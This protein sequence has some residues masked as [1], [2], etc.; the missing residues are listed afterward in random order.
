MKTKLIQSIGCH[1]N[2]VD[3]F[4]VYDKYFMRYS[5]AEEPYRKFVGCNIFIA[6]GFNPATEPNLYSKMNLNTKIEIKEGFK[7]IQE[8]ED[9]CKNLS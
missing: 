3:T 1:T 5:F 2:K 6:E 9:F 7:S 4:M 8:F